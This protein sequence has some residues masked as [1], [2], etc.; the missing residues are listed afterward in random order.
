MYIKNTSKLFV[1][2]DTTVSLRVNEIHPEPYIDY[3]GGNIVGLSDNSNEV[4]TSTFAFILSSVYSQYKDVVYVMPTEC[5]KAENLF[6]I[7]GAFN[8][9]P[10]FL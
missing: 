10:D 4:A 3:K 7:R 5:L 8:K 2:Q 9:F 6:D 1:Q